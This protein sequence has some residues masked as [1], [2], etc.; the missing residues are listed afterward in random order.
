V[1]R[2]DF[3]I[4]YEQGSART[5]RFLVSRGVPK[6]H[7]QDIAQTAWMRGWERLY[8]LRNE[9]LLSTW[10]NSI[11]LNTYRRAVYRDR[12]FQRL[13]ESVRAEAS[14]NDASID[15]SR[16]MNGCRPEERALLEAYLAGLTPEEIAAEDGVSRVAIRV[17]LFRACR[18][19]RREVERRVRVAEL[20]S[21]VA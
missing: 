3:S 4:A 8:Q 1:T 18:A 7:A 16:I 2:E 6:E 21:A 13:S 9:K 19:A 20:S 5:V 14:V 10:I 15:L 12:L 17:R 11:A